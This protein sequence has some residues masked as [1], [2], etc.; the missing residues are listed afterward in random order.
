[1]SLRCLRGR[2]MPPQMPDPRKTGVMF[3]HGVFVMLSTD[4]TGTHRWKNLAI[5]YLNVIY[6][7]HLILFMSIESLRQC[8]DS[9]SRCGVL[10]LATE[11]KG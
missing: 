6:H 9:D 10:R 2:K 11:T 8:N 7:G 3:L 5:F 1:M 4:P